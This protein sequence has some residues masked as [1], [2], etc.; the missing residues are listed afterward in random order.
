MVVANIRIDDPAVMFL[1]ELTELAGLEDAQ[2]A[3]ANALGD[4][5]LLALGDEE[6]FK[7]SE[8]WHIVSVG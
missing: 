3:I 4:A 1:G 8:E 2:E 7:W 6:F 5:A